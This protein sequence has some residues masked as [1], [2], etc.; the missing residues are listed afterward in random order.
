MSGQGLNQ[1]VAVV[2]AAIV[3][4]YT[5]SPQAALS[6]YSLIA[7]VAGVL[8]PPKGPHL[9]GPRLSELSQQV[10]SYGAQIPRVYG[11]VALT[12]CVFWI[13]GNRLRE[14]SHTESQGGK[15]GGGGAEQTTYT[16]SA[17]FAVGLADC[18]DGRPIIGVRRIWIMG[19]LVYD[20]GS[21]DVSTMIANNATVRGWR[22]YRGTDTQQP[23]PRMQADLGVA[24]CPAY[25][26]LAY[27]V[28]DDLQLEKYGNT[29]MGAQVKVELLTAAADASATLLQNKT[30]TG[31]ANLLKATALNCSSDGVMHIYRSKAPLYSAG[32]GV[33]VDYSA[34]GNIEVMLKSYSEP[35]GEIYVQGWSDVNECVFMT[36]SGNIYTAQ[37]DSIPF[38]LAKSAYAA[39]VGGQSFNYHKRG[40]TRF[41]CVESLSSATYI[42]EISSGFEV[43]VM[44]STTADP[45][46]R[47][48]DICIGE[49][50][51]YA[52]TTYPKVICYDKSWVKQWAIDLTGQVSVSSGIG[53]S[54]GFIRERA[55]GI[56]VLRVGLKF[57]TVSSAGYTFL[58]NVASFVEGNEGHGG[59]H[60]VWPM[61]LRYNADAN[62]VY[63]VRLD[64]LSNATV[65]LSSIVQAECLKSSILTLGDIDT[66]SLTD[67]VRGYR[68]SALGAIR[69]AIEPLSGAWPFDA[70]QSGYKIKFIR[71]GSLSSVATIDADSLD[72]HAFAEKPGVMLTRPREMDTQLPW[73]VTV[74]HLDYSR[75]Y[76]TGEQ[77]AE[78]LNTTSINTQ[79]IEMPI[80]LT[81]DEA[82]QRAEILLY[83]YWLERNVASFKLPPSF[84]HLE[85]SDIVTINAEGNTYSL[86]ITEI[87]YLPNGILEVSATYN[88][89]ARY[90]ST[91]VGGTS[92]VTGGTISING[93]SQMQL[94]DVPL[95][96]DSLD[97]AGFPAAMT[98]YMPGWRGGVLFRSDDG[99][100]TWGGTAAFSTK[101]YFGPAINTIPAPA[102]AAL[103]DTVS[104]LQV[105][106][107]AGS[108]SSVTELQML[109]GAN[110]FAYGIDGRWEIIAAENCALQ[111]D[112]SYLLSNLLRGRFGTEWASG[113][114]TVYDMVV[115]LDSSRLQFLQMNL[116]QIGQGKIYRPIS[117]GYT[118][119]SASDTAF[120]YRAVNLECL[121][122]I[123]LN[124]SRHPSTNDWTLTWMRRTRTGGEWRDLVDATLGES[125]EAYEVDIYS[126]GTYTTLKRTISGLAAATC[127]YS[128]AN[129]VTDF[130]SN[131]ATL[132]IKVYQLSSNVGRGYPLTTSITR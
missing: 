22:L 104:V 109:N 130:G 111:V 19:N 80:V 125:S 87:S 34:A 1:A 29:L 55:N 73:R 58:G 132:Y 121:S 92:T 97:Q 67:A 127:N 68:V 44:S 18:Y 37:E 11:S 42:T 82:M 33:R 43:L 12:G 38:F 30:L 8:N 77:Y 20:A 63:V 64:G 117:Y 59:D 47:I 120:T 6:T 10:A 116:N 103:I 112:G 94:L 14:N 91:G 95:L 2:A 126:D 74:S 123:Y 110:Y 83:M 48:N 124:G 60:L 98:G 69:S 66:T 105:Q 106:L 122:P 16:Y 28:I 53:G 129:Q 79:S 13:E 45:D 26:G 32:T 50:F 61:W 90:T 101:S 35:T 75:E 114:H 62:A 100:Q 99:G 93:P 21:S 128:S 119:D 49:N 88:D 57:Y 24:N 71:R 108:L 115:A 15:G 70:I 41:L 86:R 107:Y 89:N 4:F 7:G 17:T 27:L 51:N 76:D 81:P 65:T 9:Q 118:L 23:D 54:D 3:G 36:S 39:A 5:E 72:A 46:G 31:S 113:L 131:Q 40:K 78:R 56:V 52:I 85:P 84:G 25:R 102:S 96:L